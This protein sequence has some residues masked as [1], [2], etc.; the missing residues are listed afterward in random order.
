MVTTTTKPVETT[1]PQG[2]IAPQQSQTS[3]N[4]VSLMEK[5]V[6]TP[7]MATGTTVLL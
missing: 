7:T 4:I 1:L 5:L 3:Q 2:A 6:S